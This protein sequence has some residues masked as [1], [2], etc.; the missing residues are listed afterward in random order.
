[1]DMQLSQVVLY[2]LKW[3]CPVPGGL[4]CPKWLYVT[5]Q[6][7][8][9][10]HKWVRYVTSLYC[11]RWIRT[12]HVGLFCTKLDCTGKG[13]SVMSQVGLQLFRVGLSRS[14]FSSWSVL[15][16]YWVC[17]ISSSSALYQVGL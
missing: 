4:H 9:L 8:L 2:R 13:G 10:R 15:S 17:I 1:M 11:P 14:K 16:R 12:A 3:T 7:G 5:P 6:V